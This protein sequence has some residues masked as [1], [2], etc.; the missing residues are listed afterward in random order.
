MQTHTRDSV[1]WK[2]MVV[3]VVLVGCVS[4]TG[5]KS[6]LFTVK[7]KQKAAAVSS[8]KDFRESLLG[9]RQQ[10][11][12]TLA[13]TNAMPNSGSDMPGK[14]VI[15][16]TQLANTHDSADIIARQLAS[17]QVNKDKHISAWLGELN[18][19]NNPEKNQPGDDRLEVVRKHFDDIRSSLKKANEGYRPFLT[20]LTETDVYLQHDMTMRGVNVIRPSLEKIKETGDALVSDLNAVIASLDALTAE[21]VDVAPGD[22]AVAK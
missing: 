3:L 22:P 19:I 14:F 4:L 5:C 17:L 18:A 6:D 7:P 2:I 20:H 13:A 12:R 11:Q 16:E 1:S 10:V 9:A 15:F 21:I 8:V